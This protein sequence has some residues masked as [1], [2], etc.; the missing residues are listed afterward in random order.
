M[1]NT[2]EKYF[3]TNRQTWNEKVNVHAGSAFYDMEG[4]KKEQ[5]R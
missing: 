5:L 4:F 1:P 2:F 3:E